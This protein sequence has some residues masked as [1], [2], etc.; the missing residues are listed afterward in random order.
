MGASVKPFGEV[1]P[2]CNECGVALCWS[3]DHSEYMQW[4]I[5][6]DDWKCRD[7]NPEYEGAYRRHKALHG[8]V[9]DDQANGLG[10]PCK[11]HDEWQTKKGITLASNLGLGRYGWDIITL[12]KGTTHQQSQ[13]CLPRLR[14]QR[15]TWLV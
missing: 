12:D 1:Q 6:W 11:T 14:R 9:D 15:S 5:F 2:V 8:V 3:I 13:K 4:Q 10:R 7:C